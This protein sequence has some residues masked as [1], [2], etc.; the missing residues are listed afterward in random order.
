MRNLSLDFL[1]KIRILVRE[2]FFTLSAAAWYK[3]MLNN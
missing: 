3:K 2:P 1:L